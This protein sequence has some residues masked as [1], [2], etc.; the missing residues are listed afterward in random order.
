[1]HGACTEEVLTKQARGPSFLK[2]FPRSQGGL[3]A[4]PNGSLCTAAHIY[5]SVCVQCSPILLKV[6]TKIQEC[7]DQVAR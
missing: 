2:G 7:E 4:I 1:M 6:K 3:L 5:V